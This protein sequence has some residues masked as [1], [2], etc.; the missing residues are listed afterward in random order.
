MTLRVTNTLT[1]EKELFETLEPGHVRMYVCGPTVYS[2]AHIGHAMS[3]IV[4]DMIRRYLEY[5]GYR[6][7]FAMNFTDIDD[8]IIQRA[9]T[10]GL[11]PHELAEQLIDAWLDE[12]AALNIKPAT[13]YPRATQEIPTIIEMVK[14][15]LVKGHAYTIDGDVYFRVLSFPEYGKLSHRTLEEMLAGARVEIDPARSIPWTL[16]S[17]RLPNRA[18]QLGTVHGAPDAPD[19]ISNAA[20]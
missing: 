6:V 5:S 17:G 12:T 13:I 7:T 2:D 4:F 1:R 9:A 20:P 3:A 14:G 8:K 19:G 16:L 15:L 18:S 10:L 11:P